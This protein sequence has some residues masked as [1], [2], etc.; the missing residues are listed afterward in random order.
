MMSAVS[1]RWPRSTNADPK[2]AEQGGQ[3]ERRIGRTLKSKVLGR[4]RA[5]F[6]VSR[7]S[8]FWHEA[9]RSLLTVSCSRITRGGRCVSGCT[10]TKSIRANGHRGRGCCSIDVT[11]SPNQT[12]RTT[13]FHHRLAHRAQV[14]CTRPDRRSVS[15]LSL[16]L[17]HMRNRTPPSVGKEV[18]EATSPPSLIRSAEW[19]RI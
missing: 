9:N 17:H 8:V 18:T 16:N 19:A 5:T 2:T 12:L 15:D 6:V 3:P 4:Q 7:L 11:E 10:T 13:S 1:Q 14:V